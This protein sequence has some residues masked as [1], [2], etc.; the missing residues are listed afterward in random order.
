MSDADRHATFAEVRDQR[1][2]LNTVHGESEREIDLVAEISP[3]LTHHEITGRLEMGNNVFDTERFLK[4]GVNST[5][6][7]L[8]ARQAVARAGESDAETIGRSEAESI[9][10]LLPRWHFQ[11]EKDSVDLAAAN[12]VTTGIGRRHAGQ[13]STQLRGG[14]PYGFQ[15]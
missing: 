11:V 4:D 7:R 9:E 10:Y 13:G 14:S 2:L 3:A 15:R 1:A 6:A 5:I 12:V 8:F